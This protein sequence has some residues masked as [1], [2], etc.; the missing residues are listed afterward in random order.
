MGGGEGAW[1]MC[2]KVHGVCVKVHGG[3][4]VKVHGCVCEGAWGMCVKV[5]V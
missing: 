2:V 3:V 5:H 4:H 1:R